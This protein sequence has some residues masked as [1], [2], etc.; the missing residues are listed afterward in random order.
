MNLHNELLS[1]VKRTWEMLRPSAPPHK[2][3]RSADHLIKMNLPPL[4]GRRDAAYDCVS[5]LIADQE[6]FARDE[7]WRQKHYGI[8]A[9]L[10]ESAAEDT[11]SI[12]RTLSSPDTASRE[13]DL[14]DLIALFR[15]IVQV[16][17]DFTRL[18]S[19]VLNEEHPTFKRFGIRYTDADRLR[20]EQ[21][22]AYIVPSDPSLTVEELKEYCVHHPMLSSYKWP[23]VYRLVDELPHTATG[24]LMHY[25][26]RELAQKN[27]I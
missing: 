14:Y 17:E 23:R 11:K 7:A 26:V 25:K 9:G 2:P 21:V 24:K 10:L 1:R 15:D 6:L 16:L 12:L 5:T 18:G 13:Q 3:S 27:E 19:A 20:G 8:I 4:L 22:A